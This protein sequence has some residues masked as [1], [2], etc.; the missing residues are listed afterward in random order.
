MVSLLISMGASFH[1]ALKYD[2]GPH[3]QSGRH[4]TDVEHGGVRL[5]RWLFTVGGRRRKERRRQR[6]LAG[7]VCVCGWEPPRF[8]PFGSTALVP[9]QF[10]A[11]RCPPRCS[12]VVS[13]LF[14]LPSRP[15][16]P[17]PRDGVAAVG[18]SEPSVHQN[19]MNGC[20]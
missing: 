13:P 11:P 7:C 20:Q 16:S 14:P 3:R 19:G 9:I 10:G 2:S 5:C 18:T 6:T 12:P 4:R 17:V 1:G 8:Q 15:P